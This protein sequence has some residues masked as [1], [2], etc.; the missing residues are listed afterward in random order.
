VPAEAYDNSQDFSDISKRFLNGLGLEAITRYG[1]FLLPLSYF[2]WSVMAINREKNF[3]EKSTI[4]PLKV[5]RILIF[6]GFAVFLGGALTVPFF[7][8]TQ[9]LWYKT[10]ID[11]VVLR[12]GQLAGLF[13]L[14]LLVLQILLSL[15]GKFL[16]DLFG[17]A[18]LMRRH[19]TNGVLIAGAAISHVLLVLAPEGIGNLPIGKKYWPEM[20]GGG[21]FLLILIT[22]LSSHFRSA[23]N[24]DYMVWKKVHKPLGYLHLILLLIHVLFV[25]ESFRQGMPRGILLTIFSGLA[26]LVAVVKTVHWKSKS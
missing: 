4:F 8:E 23:L 5:Y 17:G 20:T 15:R 2:K 12:A 21:L 16:E 13:A 10:G 24:L 11:K 25:S 19:R 6:F 22:V 7:Y 1:K 18:N 14:V 26:L 9:T 3:S